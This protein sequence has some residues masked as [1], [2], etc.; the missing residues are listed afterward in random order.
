MPNSPLS[1]L[2][3]PHFPWRG[4]NRFALWVDGVQFFPQML[5]AIEQAQRSIVIEMYLCGSGA[6]FTQFRQ[7]LIAAAQRGVR[8]RLLL[9]DFG[10]LQ[11]TRSERE[12][13]L[14][15]GIEM[16]FYNRLRWRKGLRNLFRNHRK[17]MVV[18]DEL[19]FTGGL[20]LTDEFMHG[21]HGQPA[22]HDLVLEIHGPVV[23]DWSELFE[24]TW[25]GMYRSIRRRAK[26]QQPRQSSFGPTPGRVVAGNGPR[27]HQVMQSVYAALKAARHRAWVVTPYFVPSW[28]L[29]RLLMGAARRGIDVRVLVPGHLTDHPGIRHVSHRHYARLLQHGV[30]IFEYQPR[31]IHAKLMICDDWLTLGST[32]FDSWNL[33]WNLDAN[34]EVRDAALLE[35]MVRVV[36]ADFAL[37]RELHY[38]SWLLRPR[39]VR[40]LEWVTG[41]LAKWLGKLR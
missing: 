3:P 34:Q 10:A 33:H 37:S 35:A 29:R 23:T 6:V 40:L 7:A 38:K 27:A 11:L 26:P 41:T 15:G 4:G 25:I 14:K 12:L 22:W 1:R 13:L 30:R 32:N 8:V 24:R 19:A 16:R 21:V 5:A 39:S 17:L 36:E 31:F 18:D 20:G 9:D 2:L 28:K